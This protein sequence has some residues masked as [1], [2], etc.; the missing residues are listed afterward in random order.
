M[1]KPPKIGAKRREWLAHLTKLKLKASA[2][3]APAS[4]GALL[5]VPVLVGVPV[6][7]VVSHER[8]EELAWVYARYKLVD[9][10]RTEYLKCPMCGSGSLW[11]DRV[12]PGVVR[13]TK[14][15]A[16][17]LGLFYR[18]K[19]LSCFAT[20]PTTAIYNDPRF[21]SLSLARRIAE[22]INVAHVDWLDRMRERFSVA[23]EKDSV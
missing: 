4:L 23:P 3:N 5:K 10:G 19:C 14:T 6:D 11:F 16:R 7:H 13:K 21:T 20:G 22:A 18:V 1:P 8:L 15:T 2:K 17:R 9:S 12:R